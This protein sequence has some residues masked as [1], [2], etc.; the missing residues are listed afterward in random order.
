MFDV[1]CTDTLK[2]LATTRDDVPAALR[3][4]NKLS[5]ILPLTEKHLERVVLE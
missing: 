1:N 4:A 2:T 5:E 3:D